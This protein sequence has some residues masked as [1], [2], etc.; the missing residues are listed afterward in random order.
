M[1]DFSLTWFNSGIVG[2]SWA[3]LFAS[4]G[5]QVRLYDTDQEALRLGLSE[6]RQKLQSLEENGDLKSSD[7]LSAKE[8]GALISGKKS[9]GILFIYTCNSAKGG[10]NFKKVVFN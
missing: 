4:G 8:Q 3:M 7:E 6:V 10:F 9:G 5:H 2:K 1:P